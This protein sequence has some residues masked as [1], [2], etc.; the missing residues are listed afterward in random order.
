MLAPSEWRFRGS[1]DLGKTRVCIVAAKA[2]DAQC[3]LGF[4]Q[5]FVGNL[6][7]DASEI[8]EEVD[9]YLAS[10]GFDQCP[11]LLEHLDDLDPK[12]PAL[13]GNGIRHRRWIKR[14]SERLSHS[15]AVLPLRDDQ[16]GRT[17]IR[18]R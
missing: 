8:V 18:R 15:Q 16:G 14:L 13:N 3:G 12:V 6:V 9:G 11:V 1:E 17:S 5:R 7:E 2:V 10:L 4:R